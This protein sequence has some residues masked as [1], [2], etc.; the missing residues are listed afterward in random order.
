MKP[1][2]ALIIIV[3]CGHYPRHLL[4]SDFKFSDSL[5]GNLIDS[6]DAKHCNVETI[7]IRYIRQNPRLVT[8]SVTFWKGCLP[9]MEF[10]L[11]IDY[12]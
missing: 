6:Q 5:S 8:A 2:I 3:V 9:S 4:I 1:N 7:K 10:C 11:E 12:T